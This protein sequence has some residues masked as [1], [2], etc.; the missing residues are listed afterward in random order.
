MNETW[1]ICDGKQ[2]FTVNDA[3]KWWD[4]HYENE[5]DIVNAYNKDWISK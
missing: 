2:M 3:L 5:E 4:V 1:E